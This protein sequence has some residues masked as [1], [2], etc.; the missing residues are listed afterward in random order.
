MTVR[1]SFSTTRSRSARRAGRHGHAQRILNGRLDVD[2]RQMRFAVRL[3][4]GIR[5]HAMF[6]HRQRHQRHAEPGGD[7]LDEGIGQRLDA[8]AAAGR[9]HR[10]KRGRDALPAVGGED[11]LLRVRATSRFGAR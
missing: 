10:G 3:L 2:R 5:T 7:A 11:D 9:H 4:H 1:S 8:A 6:V